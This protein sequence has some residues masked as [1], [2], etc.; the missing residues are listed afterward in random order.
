MMTPAGPVQ[1][2]QPGKYRT[3]LLLPPTLKWAVE[4]KLPPIDAL[5][6][7]TSEAAKIAAPWQVI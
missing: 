4:H 1:R 7:I 2:V 5:A 6:R 3:E